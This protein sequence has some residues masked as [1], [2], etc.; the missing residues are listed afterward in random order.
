VEKQGAADSR[1]IL[2][3]ADRVPVGADPDRIAADGDQQNGG[4]EATLSIVGPLAE[5]VLRSSLGQAVRE[6]LRG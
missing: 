2:G 6:V 1:M 4:Y 5:S 3:V